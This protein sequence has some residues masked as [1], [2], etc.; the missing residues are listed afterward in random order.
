IT[1]FGSPRRTSANRQSSETAAAPV[2]PAPT[3]SINAAQQHSQHLHDSTADMAQVFGG[4][5]ALQ[6][7]EGKP[8]LNN[9][10]VDTLDGD[11]TRERA[12]SVP[13]VVESAK[14]ESQ[15]QQEGESDDSGGER[16]QR[17]K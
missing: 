9:N 12:P 6:T 14:R 7:G 2:V 1:D 4:P 15:Q 8:L 3:T 17:K 5:N 16:M 11:K 10:P 13:A